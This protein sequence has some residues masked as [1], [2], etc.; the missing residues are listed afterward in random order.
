MKKKALA[1]LLPLTAGVALTGTG[2]GIWVFNKEVND[3]VNGQIGLTSAIEAH[4]LT[5]T[6][7]T[8]KDLGD[9]EFLADKIILDQDDTV[10]KMSQKIYFKLN[11]DSSNGANYATKDVTVPFQIECLAKLPSGLENYIQLKEFSHNHDTLE[12]LTLKSSE[13]RTDGIYSLFNGVFKFNAADFEE[14][15]LL[16]NTTYKSYTFNLTYSYEWKKTTGGTNT[17][18]KPTTY[19]QYNKVRK[20]LNADSTIKYTF[21]AKNFG[22]AH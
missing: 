18:M 15:Y 10:S 14:G 13:V 1:L 3:T 22:V 2:F 20:I 21:T 4:G 17:T 16:E 19:D 12:S 6:N 11:I 5:I 9:D 8:G 7:E